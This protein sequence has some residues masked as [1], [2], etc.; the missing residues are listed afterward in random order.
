MGILRTF[1]A[2]AVALAHL[3]YGGAVMAGDTAVQAF[4][5]CSGFYMAMTWQTKYASCG[6]APASFG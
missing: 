2:L 1:L 3:G 5:V 4:Y 6:T